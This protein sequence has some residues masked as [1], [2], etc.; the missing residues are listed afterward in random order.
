[1]KRSDEIKKAMDGFH[2]VDP[3][4]QELLFDSDD[5]VAAAVSSTLPMDEIE[6]ILPTA[7]VSKAAKDELDH[8]LLVM[9]MF[10]GDGKVETVPLG[11]TAEEFAK[12]RGERPP[13]LTEMIDNAIRKAV[14]A[15]RGEPPEPLEK[16]DR[17]AHRSN[18]Q[19]SLLDAA[20]KFGE[21][22]RASRFVKAFHADDRGT[23]RRICR[24]IVRSSA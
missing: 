10:G 7:P 13:T 2:S 6:I 20:E 14:S 24:D 21:G 9:E 23:M 12:I 4:L 19:F 8:E 1:M 17:A 16:F 22:D 3:L 11:M 5:D 18:G 15:A